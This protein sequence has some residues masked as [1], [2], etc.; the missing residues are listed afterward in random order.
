[1]S[2]HRAQVVWKLETSEKAFASGHYERA[3]TLIFAEGRRRVPGSASPSVVPPPFSLADALDPEAAFTGALS[4]CHMLWLLDLARRD[5]FVVVAYDD[6][7]EGVLG[8]DGQGRMCMTRVTL[9][10]RIRWGGARHPT[11]EEVEDLHFRAHEQ[12]FI[13]NSVKTA[14]VVDSRPTD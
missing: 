13:A 12:C 10:P 1:M 9:R 11:A 5:G 6:E 4:A 14:I 8:P 7:A 3:H 2:L